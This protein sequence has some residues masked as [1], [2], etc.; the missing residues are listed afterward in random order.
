M[1]RLCQL[2]SLRPPRPPRRVFSSR[3]TVDW[4]LANR[5]TEILSIG[6]PFRVGSI[7]WRVFVPYE[8]RIS[9]GASAHVKK[10][11]LALR[12]D[13]DQHRWMFDGGI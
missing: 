12:N 5:P 6:E 2:A 10:W 7:E 3:R 11:N 8:V 9:A 4:L 13:N 1:A